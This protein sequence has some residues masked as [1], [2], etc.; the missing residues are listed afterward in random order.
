MGEQRLANLTKQIAGGCRISQ[1]NVLYVGA[2]RARC[3]IHTQNVASSRNQTS[4]RLYRHLPAR[5]LIRTNAAAENQVTDS[6]REAQEAPAAEGAIRFAYDLKEP[7]AQVAGDDV[8]L[9][10]RAWREIFMRLGGVGQTPDRYQGLGFGNLSARDPD[11]PEEFVITASQTGGVRHL[12][13]EDLTRVVGCNLDRFWV[14]AEGSQPPSSETLTHAM[15]YAADPRIEW[16]FHCH[17]PEL[18]QAAVALALPTTA[19]DVDYGSPEMVVAV[20]ELLAGHHSRPLVFATL[21]HEDGIFACGSTARDTGG[22]LVSYLAR[23]LQVAPLE[24]S[25][26]EEPENADDSP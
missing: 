12:T 22:L 17:C 6:D 24:E 20:A 10:I 15:I 26:P 7:A 4:Q 25:D 23:S 21:G 14:D 8:L 5:F 13:D 1:G 3:F 18:W 9:Q 16:V 19:R 2:E 11:Q